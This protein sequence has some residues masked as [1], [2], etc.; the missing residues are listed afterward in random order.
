[1]NTCVLC[2]ETGGE[3]LYQDDFVRIV[4]AGEVAYPGFTRVILQQHLKEMS[5]LAQ[6]ERICLMEYVYT[7][8]QAQ[9]DILMPEKINLAQFGTMVPHI[10]WH[11][12]PRFSWDLHYP[13]SFWSAPVHEAKTAEYLAQLQAQ[14]NLQAHYRSHLHSR[15]AELNSL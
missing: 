11:I 6:A 3:L 14:H 5:E 1:M 2:R 15:L 13:G 10:H 8:E 4:N 12:I 7:V 9:R